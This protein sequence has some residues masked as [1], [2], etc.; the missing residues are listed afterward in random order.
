MQK[1][2][3]SFT[4]RIILIERLT[5]CRNISIMR[6]RYMKYTPILL[7]ITVLIAFSFSGFRKNESLID[8]E[9]KVKGL[10]ERKKFNFTDSVISIVAVG[11][12]M[13][14]TNYPSESYLPPKDVFLLNPVS[15]I[16]SQADLTF[17]NLE[18]TILNSGGTPKKCSDPSLC[19]AFRQPEYFVQQLKNAGFDFM[20]VANNHMG[21]FGDIGRLNTC[22]VLR[23]N[24]IRYAGLISCPW[25]TLTYNGLKIGLT[26]FAPNSGCLSLNDDKLIVQ[27]VKKLSEL[28]DI[29][30]FSFHGGAEGS[31]KTHITR[32]DEL[33]L[34]E[35]RGNVYR[36]A[37]LAIDAG[38][39]LV[40]GH[41]PHV[42]RAIDYYKGRFITYSMGNFCT[43]GRFNLSGVSGIAPIFKINVKRDGSFISGKITSIKQLGEG[44]PSLDESQGALEQI[45]NLT[46][47]DLP[48]LNVSFNS[49]GDFDF[50]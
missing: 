47:I 30:I 9:L 19:Y 27:T 32:S 20:S 46:K 1:N 12:I 49:V 29:V 42:T 34:G 38:A 23:S 37:R 26:A 15:E 43:Y 36:I 3:A 11:D 45:K 33:F 17:G 5:S 22:K 21:D 50:H 13:M 48:E 39:D 6:F 7:I 44:G 8:N 14:G 10:T 24:G 18:G 41:G 28:C 2:S 25:D 31:S 35:N 16:L 4:S 40:L